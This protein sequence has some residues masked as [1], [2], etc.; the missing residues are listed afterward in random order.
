[1]HFVFNL[2]NTLIKENE[3]FCTT[4]SPAMGS[5][6]TEDAFLTSQG[7]QNS[8]SLF[9]ALFS[10]QLS[11]NSS[12]KNSPTSQTSSTGNVASGP[13]EAPGSF[14]KQTPIYLKPEL[15]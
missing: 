9:D 4:K 15:L 13:K 8:S 2:N 1:M 5:T 7:S 6:S 10:P 12:Q 3:A 11:C 14:L